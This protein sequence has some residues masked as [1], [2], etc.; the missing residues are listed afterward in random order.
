MDI[1]GGDSTVLLSVVRTV[2]I[3]GCSDVGSGQLRLMDWLRGEC[4]CHCSFLLD[5]WTSFGL[6]FLVLSL[7]P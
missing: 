2:A 6:R 5:G 3:E 4:L 1:L 7:P